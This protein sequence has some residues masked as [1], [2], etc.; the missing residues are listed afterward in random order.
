M[1]ANRTPKKTI[2]RRKAAARPRTTRQADERD[3][4]RDPEGQVPESD[5]TG[6]SLPA[7]PGRKGKTARGWSGALAPAG[8]ATI[9][10]VSFGVAFPVCV[11]SAIFRSIGRHITSR[12]PQAIS[13]SANGKAEERQ[14]GRR[15]RTA[16]GRHATKRILAH[17]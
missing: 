5:D 11:V 7:D 2:I 17:A 14:S 6:R 10:A 4:R 16:G 3:G 1:P 12:V 9:Y 15:R 13:P 8:Y